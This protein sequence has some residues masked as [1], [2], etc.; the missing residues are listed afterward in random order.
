MGDLSWE[1][2]FCLPAGNPVSTVLV[3]VADLGAGNTALGKAGLVASS[4]REKPEGHTPVGAP[5]LWSY[6]NGLSTL[7]SVVARGW[8]FVSLVIN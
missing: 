3:D 2:I 1:R 7:R 6:R 4:G 8:G 5:T